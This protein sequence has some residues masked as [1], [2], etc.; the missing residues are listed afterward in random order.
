MKS[1]II[2]WAIVGFLIGIGSSLAEN[3][4][5]STAFWRA[6]AGALIVALLARWWTNIWLDSL[7]DAIRQ[8]QYKRPLPISKPK[9]TAKA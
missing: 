7:R 1:F 6:C 4:S 8:R 5:W 9:P 3:C 2:L